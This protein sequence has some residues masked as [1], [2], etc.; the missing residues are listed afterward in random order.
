M[1]MSHLALSPM[2]LPQMLASEAASWQAAPQVPWLWQWPSP[3]ML[4]RFAFKL[5]PG[6][7]VAGNTKALWRRTRPL[8]VR[9]GSEAS[10]KVSAW[11][12]LVPSSSLFSLVSQVTLPLLGTSPNVARNAIVNCTELVTYDLIKDTILKANLMAGERGKMKLALPKMWMEK[13]EMGCL[14]AISYILSPLGLDFLLPL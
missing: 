2:V 5:R 9:K 8:P 7:E 14:K 6:L 11:V 4:S 3:Q 10:G 1:T 12:P 13:G